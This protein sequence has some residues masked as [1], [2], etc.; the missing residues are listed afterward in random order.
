M[1]IYIFLTILSILWPR[2]K[3]LM[4]KT[5]ALIDN[6][7]YRLNTCVTLAHR[8]TWTRTLSVLWLS[9]QDMLSRDQRCERSVASTSRTHLSLFFGQVTRAK[10]CLQYSSLRDVPQHI[11]TKE[12]KTTTKK[13]SENN[14]S[15]TP[16]DSDADHELAAGHNHNACL[17]FRLP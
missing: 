15:K 17:K 14:S 4:K 13:N 6:N 16:T 11:I 1:F 8:Q 9:W 2:K 12:K 5:V 3:M 7:T 10:I